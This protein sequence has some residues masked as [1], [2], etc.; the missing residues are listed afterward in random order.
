MG[1]MLIT[2]GFCSLFLP[3]TMKEHLPQTL[4]DSE[5]TK[6]DCFA[7]CRSPETNFKR[8]AFYESQM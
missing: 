3:E 2:G 6:L 5:N 7:C 1:V 8:Q 4:Q